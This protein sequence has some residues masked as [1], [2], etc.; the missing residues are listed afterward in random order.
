MP[1]TLGKISGKSKEYFE[2]ASSG[3]YSH[4]IR[5]DGWSSVMEVMAD[6]QWNLLSV[7]WEKHENT[8]FIKRSA[9]TYRNNWFNIAFSTRKIIELYSPIFF[10][11]QQVLLKVLS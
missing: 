2:I 4:G 8:F 11:A 5:S 7:N 6:P 1:E 3:S 9:D 10:V